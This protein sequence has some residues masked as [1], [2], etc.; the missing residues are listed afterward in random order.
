MEIII[1]PGSCS[2]KTNWFDQIQHF[3]DLGHN[4][5]FV[6]LPDKA[7]DLDKASKQLFAS[8]W[9]TRTEIQKDFM[10]TGLHY[11]DDVESML[12][13]IQHKKRILPEERERGF[14]EVIKQE[15]LIICHS[16]GGMQILNILSDPDL[17]N[18]IDKD[19]YDFISESH[20]LFTQVPLK[21]CPSTHRY[22]E[23]FSSVFG[24]LLGL[25][26]KH[27]F[28]AT[29][30][31]LK[32]AKRAAQKNTLLKP[33]NWL[34]LTNHLS[35]VNSVLGKD[36]SCFKNLVNYYKDWDF[37]QKIASKKLSSYTDR[38]TFTTG[39]PDLFCNNE[40]I[41]EFAK[42]QGAKTINFPWSFHVPMHISWT[43]NTFNQIAMN[44]KNKS[45]ITKA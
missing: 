16:M 3:T 4:V 9:Q 11:T 45:E 42:L 21:T 25:Y 37:M 35:M 36:P 30:S 2:S 18:V 26:S 22:C 44:L 39:D 28:K 10:K 31:L 8:L 12:K 33:L 40:I 6:D 5:H 15:S 13:D 43:Q 24:P 14:E 27:I 23:I 20:I 19:T 7:E 17:F 41:K 32:K 34:N 38:Y 1:I 29:D